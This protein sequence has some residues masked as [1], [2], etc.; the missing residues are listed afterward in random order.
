MSRRPADI[1]GASAALT[2]V[3]AHPGFRPGQ[4]E[5]VESVLAGEDVLAVMPTGAGKSLLYQLPAVAGHGSV[6]VISPLISLMRDQVIALQA[7]GVAAG[8]LNSASEPDEAARVIRLIATRRIDLLYLAPERLARSAT[9]DML[10]RLKPQLIAVDEAHCVSRWA[11]DFR[12]DYGEIRAVAASLGSPQMIAVTAT[13]ATRTRADIVSRLFS[14]QPRTFVRSFARPNIA[15]SFR[16]RR[17][18][19]ADVRSIVASHAGESGIIYCASRAGTDRLARDLDHAGIRA[20]PY[21]AGLDSFTRDANQDRFLRERG[22]VMV[23]TIAFGMGIDKPDVRFVCHADLPHSVEAYYQEIGRAGRDGLPASAIA[24][25]DRRLVA[26][27]HALSPDAVEMLTLAHHPGCRWQF[28]LAHFGEPSRPCGVCDLCTRDPLRLRRV[29]LRA[30]N[31]A[32]ATRGALAS[33]ILRATTASGAEPETDVM[34]ADLAPPIVS[35]VLTASQARLRARL[36]VE[37][38]R[39]ARTRRIPPAAIA[40]DC[41]L[42]KLAAIEPMPGDTHDQQAA[43]IIGSGGH[44]DA[45]AELLTVLAAE[46]TR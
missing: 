43:E 39:I 18:A 45:K 27:K 42:D 46:R 21:H 33:R 41:L 44:Q 3:F 31:L 34:S 10:K 13:A 30:Q 24:L 17:D 5:I 8:A 1:A 14:R 35:A 4:R 26:A 12:P 32:L 38:A 2:R 40:T 25:V 19:S 6:I 7:K 15:L 36:S 9:L 20:F 11:D 22:T 28:V 29:M 37:R 16:T 23:A